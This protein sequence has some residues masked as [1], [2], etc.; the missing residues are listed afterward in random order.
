[1]VDEKKTDNIREVQVD[2]LLVDLLVIEKELEAE[3]YSL[4]VVALVV[5]HLVM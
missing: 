1:M 2:D 3:V 4:T 5:H